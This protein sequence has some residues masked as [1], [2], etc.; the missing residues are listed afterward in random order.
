MSWEATAYVKDLQACPDGSPLNRGQKLLAFVLADYHNSKYRTAWPSVPTLAR[1]S[2][3]SLA[4]AKRDLSYLEEHFLIRKVRPKKTGRGWVCAYQ[5]MEI[6][7][8]KELGAKVSERKEGVHHDPLFCA[9]E[10]GPERVHTDEQNG[11]ERAQ[12]GFTEPDAIRK[13]EELE[14]PINKEHK[15]SR[16][17]EREETDPRHIPIREAIKREQDQAHVPIQWNGRSAKTLSDW[18][19]ANPRVTAEEAILFVSNKF[20]SEETHGD[21]PWQWIP[22]LSKYSQGPV[23]RFGKP[24]EADW[25][26]G[27]EGMTHNSSECEVNMYRNLP[28]FTA[29]A[30]DFLGDAPATRAVDTEE[31]DPLLGA[32]YG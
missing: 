17:H 30:F 21:P 7:A 26:V 15:S 20:M 3:T 6:D 28:G 27:Y 29:D 24:P 31:E 11:S 10:S 25:R 13:N 22:K 23:D 4:Q 16:S 14:P 2:L 9:G 12:K 1:E 5:F 19:R 18:L 8:P 32:Y